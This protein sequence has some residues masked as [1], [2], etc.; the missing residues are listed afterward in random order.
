MGLEA[1]VLQWGEINRTPIGCFIGIFGEY[2]LSSEI[3]ESVFGS[4]RG[5][6]GLKG[7]F[8]IG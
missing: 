8:D 1:D 5:K 2:E 3:I 4:L 6:H 7:S